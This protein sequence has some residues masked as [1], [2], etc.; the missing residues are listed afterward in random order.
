MVTLAEDNGLA[1]LLS[2][3]QR[4]PQLFQFFEYQTRFHCLFVYNKEADLGW[5]LDVLLLSIIDLN[6]QISSLLIQ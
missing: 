6:G 3:G 4:L 2:L 1:P 5:K